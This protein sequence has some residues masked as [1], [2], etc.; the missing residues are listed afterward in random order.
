[1]DG[2]LSAAVGAWSWSGRLEAPWG[3]LGFGVDL[4]GAARALSLRVD[5]DLHYS[6][7]GQ[8]AVDGVNQV[9]VPDDAIFCLGDNTTNS[10][11]SRYREVG[12]IPLSSIIGPVLF[13]I[14][15]PSRLGGVR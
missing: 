7:D 3:P 6:N 13:R 5:R 15:P 11:D 1:V 4:G 8:F 14:W 10:T 12:P 2:I 9:T